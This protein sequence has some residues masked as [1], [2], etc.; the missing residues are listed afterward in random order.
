MLD[1]AGSEGGHRVAKPQAVVQR[2][3]VNHPIC[4]KYAAPQAYYV[5][6]NATWNVKACLFDP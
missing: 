3:A 4:S 2:H 1:A 5:S 6:V